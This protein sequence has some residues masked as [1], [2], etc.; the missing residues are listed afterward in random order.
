MRLKDQA[1]EDI[2][3]M[4][5]KSGG[6]KFGDRNGWR[7]LIEVANRSE[8]CDVKRLKSHFTI[9]LRVKSQVSS[10]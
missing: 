7:R 6:E 10:K 3:R 8:N 4:C 2:R 5:R 9:P 1:I